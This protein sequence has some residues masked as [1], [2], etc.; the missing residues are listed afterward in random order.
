MPP[1]IALLISDGRPG[2]FTLSEGILAAIARRRPVDVHRLEVQR[3][4]MLPGRML[5]ALTNQGVSPQTVLKAAYGIDAN[6]LPRADLV[7]SAGGDT[8]A[9]N[10]AAARVLGGV[11][12]A[13]YGSL[14]RFNPD[15]FALVLNSYARYASHPKYLVTLKPNKLDPDE[16]RAP[17]PQPDFASGEP[18]RTAGLLLGGDTPT[19][20]F[21]AANWQR[22]LD[23]MRAA[24]VQHGTRWMV[25]NSRRTPDEVSTQFAALAATP[26]SP[27]A[28]FIDVREAGSGTLR[29]IFAA[30]DAVAVTADSSSMLSEAIWVRRHVVALMPEGS[31]LPADEQDYRNFLSA[32]GWTTPLSLTGLTPQSWLTSLSNLTPLGANPLDLLADE[33]QRR[34][35]DVFK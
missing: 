20:K 31:S 34:V 16:V 8:L 12:N 15:D 18:P 35:P 17:S 26:A 6:T 22:I 10:I 21:G 4:R 2:H 25:S 30:S 1:L 19:M 5:S 9:A 29:E 14:R 24:H 33:L 27:I 11:P 13:F 3:R 23:F 32:S 28:R 7:V